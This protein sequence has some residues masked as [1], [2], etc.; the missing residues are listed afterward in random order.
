[1]IAKTVTSERPNT[2]V[3]SSDFLIGDRH[4]AFPLD[5]SAVRSARFGRN[6]FFQPVP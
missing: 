1:M 6:T 4:G 3:T 5:E 2:V